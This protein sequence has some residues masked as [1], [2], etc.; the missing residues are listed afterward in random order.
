VKGT[1]GE[2]AVSPDGRYAVT[3]GGE[4]WDT[5]SN[6]WKASGDYALRLWRLPR[7]VWAA[8]PARPSTGDAAS[9]PE[10]D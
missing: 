10:L 4:E 3:A 6:K 9:Q 1:N 7:S 2:V 5:D 8:E